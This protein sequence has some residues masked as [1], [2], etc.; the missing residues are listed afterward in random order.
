MFSEKDKAA[1]EKYFGVR[2][3][4]LDL[5]KLKKLQRELRAKYHPD[6]FEK[7]E[8]E[9]VREMATERFQL[10][11][12]L[13]AKLEIYL[14][15]KSAN[16]G[17]AQKEGEDF[18]NAHAVFAANKLKIEVITTDKDLKYHLFGASYRW[19]QF[20]DKYKIPD[21]KAFIIIDEDHMGRSIGYQESIR[22]YL[23][24]DENDS[25]EKMVEW[26]YPRIKDKAKSL[27]ISGERIEIEPFSIFYAIRK[28]AFLRVELPAAS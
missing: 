28:K 23:T 1:I 20:G 9:T 27:L 2:L 22:M 12:D 24:F 3:E 25:I 26:L 19:L 14:S 15:G 4:E 17:F 8:D 18:M 16:A 7:F 6:N 13:S 11:E 21:T 10:I 5:E